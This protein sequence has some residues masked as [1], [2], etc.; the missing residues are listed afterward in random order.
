M[1]RVGWDLH[2]ALFAGVYS[3]CKQY[4]VPPSF[5]FFTIIFAYSHT[6]LQKSLCR[7]DQVGKIVSAAQTGSIPL[8]RQ[9]GGSEFGKE[10]AAPDFGAV[11]EA[12]F[13]TKSLK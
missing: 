3:T 9:G 2:W 1:D 13:F 6:I 7:W 8:Y 11:W 4:E 12:F 10:L 5:R